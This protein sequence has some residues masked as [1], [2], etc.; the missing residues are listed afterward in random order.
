[1]KVPPVNINQ[2]TAMEIAGIKSVNTLK[3]RIK[4]GRL[5][6]PTYIDGYRFYNYEKFKKA[7]EA[8]VD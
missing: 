3:K 4:E 5:P 7:C 2:K 1:M 8:M 6:E